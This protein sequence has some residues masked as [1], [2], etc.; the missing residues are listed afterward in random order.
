VIHLE[1][2]QELEVHQVA[3]RVLQVHPEAFL[4]LLTAFRDHLTASLGL[5]VAFQGL[6]VAFQGLLQEADQAQLLEVSQMRQ[7]AFQARVSTYRDL[8]YYLKDQKVKGQHLSLEY[9]N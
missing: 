1:A 7:V 4:D 5:Q 2:F 3:F 9:G 8:P 6:Q